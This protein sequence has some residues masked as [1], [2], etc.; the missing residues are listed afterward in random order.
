MKK[1]FLCREHMV[2]VGYIMAE[3]KEKE[4]TQGDVRNQGPRNITKSHHATN[5]THEGYWG[6]R[7]AGGCLEQEQRE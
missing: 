3:R 4:M 5:L 1:T 2:E 6:H 7:M